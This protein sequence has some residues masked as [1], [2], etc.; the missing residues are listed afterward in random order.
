M[1]DTDNAVDI[2]ELA[3]ERGSDGQLLPVKKT[4]EVR[5]EGPADLKVIPATSGQRREWKQSLEDDGDGEVS[6]DLEADLLDTF[7]P[8][9][10]SD[11]GADEWSDIRPALSDALANA[12]FAELFDT[13]EDDFSQAL[14]DATEEITGAEGNAEMG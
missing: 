9:T 1:T 14:A 8:Y 12:V 13:G 7:T 5:G 10:P 11:F 3:H 4:V 6:D 2:T